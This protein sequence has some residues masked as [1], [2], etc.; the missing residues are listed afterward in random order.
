MRSGSTTLDLR[1][2]PNYVSLMMD[3]ALAACALCAC[4]VC[5]K[6]SERSESEK[7]MVVYQGS[8]HLAMLH[9]HVPGCSFVELPVEPD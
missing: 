6:E 1:N 7:K 8:D 2:Y 5:V 9:G 3:G 4:W